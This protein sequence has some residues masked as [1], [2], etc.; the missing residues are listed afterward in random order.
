MQVT[1]RGV[2]ASAENIT[3]DHGYFLVVE[4]DNVCTISFLDSLLGQ[5]VAP[6]YTVIPIEYSITKHDYK[7]GEI[8]TETQTFSCTEIDA[9]SLKT[10]IVT[11][12]DTYTKI[13][14]AGNIALSNAEHFHVVS[15]DVKTTAFHTK[16]YSGSFTSDISVN[17]VLLI[18]YFYDE[19]YDTVQA[20][21]YAYSYRVTE[22]STTEF[23]ME[24]AEDV[25]TDHCT[26]IAYYL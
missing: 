5:G 9:S 14:E 20:T 25:G 1:V 23:Q 16:Q 24:I 19:S 17:A 12:R 8:V 6:L 10:K 3:E 11:E 22:N 2:Y 26:L 21:E 15:T 18:A 7:K 4:D 13:N